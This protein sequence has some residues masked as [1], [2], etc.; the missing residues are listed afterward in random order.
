M[1]PLSMF[2]SLATLLIGGSAVFAF[3]GKP[4]RNIP[5][6]RKWKD[7]LKF[8]PIQIGTD[9]EIFREPPER[10]AP[11]TMKSIWSLGDEVEAELPIG[12][13]RLEIG[14]EVPKRGPQTAAQKIGSSDEVDVAP[15]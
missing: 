1:R 9:T 13:G 5:V 15:R 10:R 12:I 7:L 4:A 6:V 8:A 14:S 3:D 11:T 2:V